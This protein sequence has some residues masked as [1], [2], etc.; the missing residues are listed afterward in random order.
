MPT[1]DYECDACS[2][3]FEHFQS[4]TSNIRRKCPECGEKKLRR[5]IGSGAG[6]IFKGSGFYETDYKRKQPPPSSNGDSKTSDASES[7][8]KDTK[9]KAKP[10]ESST[11]SKQSD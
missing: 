8:K 6:V 5:L 4:M 10:A 2:H 3:H 1:Y 9:D 7:A 11:K